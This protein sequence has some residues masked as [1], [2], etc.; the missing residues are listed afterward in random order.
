[1]NKELEVKVLGIDL[2]TLEKKL[3]DLGAVLR[4]DEHQINRIYAPPALEGSKSYLRIRSVKDQLVNEERTELTLK[5]HLHDEGVRTNLE[6]TTEVES[7]EVLATILV[8]IGIGEGVVAE[9]MRKSYALK[10]AIIDLDRWS[11]EI[12]PDPYA[13]IEVESPEQLEEIL[14]LL[15][16]EEKMLST[17][18]I[19]EL[20]AEKN[21]TR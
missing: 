6:F 12:Y 20:I 5:Q 3:L 10:G 11:D 16:I 15:G 8:K 9:K 17:K 7:G 4:G 2:D 14:A 13:E 19:K 21:E 1:M 18:S